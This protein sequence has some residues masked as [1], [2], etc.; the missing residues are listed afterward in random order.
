M[1]KIL[2]FEKQS[3]DEALKIVDSLRANGHKAFFV[4]GC[5]RD[6]LLG[7]KPGEIDITTSARPDEVQRLFLRTVPIGESFGVVLVLSNEQQ[8]E[9]ATFRTESKYNDGRHPELVKYSKSEKEDVLRRD[10]TI[11]GLLYDPFK[12]EL[13]DYTDG[14]ADLESNIIRTIGNPI[15]RFS[16]DKLRMIRAVRFASRFGFEIENE[17]Y[18]AI[19]SKAAD[20]NTISVER[21]REEIVKIITQKNPGIGLKMLKDSGLLEHILPEVSDMS[22]VKQPPEFHPEGDVF[23]HTCLVLDKL[24]ENT[25]G[26]YSDELAMGALLHDIGKPPTFQDLD[27]IRFNG[28]DRV[29]AKMAQKICKDL[30]FSKK[31]IERIS[32]IVRDHLKFKDAFSMRESTLK[33]FLGQPYFHEHLEMHLADCMASHGITKV[34][35]FLKDKLEEYSELDI[36]PE[37]LI[38][39]KD[40]ISMG[41]KPGPIFT[42]ILNATEEKQ[43]E[44]KITNKDEAIEFVNKTFSVN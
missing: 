42:T 13:F 1:K 5:V 34:Y 20:I 6:S 14:L 43:L 27:R 22:G 33:R 17:T 19:T 2:D 31:Q 26:E 39:G 15:E 9:V 29:G 37:P 41:Y 32:D 7:F 28:H 25:N 36:R 40:L 16:E 21:I 30:R 3:Y 35:Y 23:V 24:Y 11:N 4:G 8:F 10:F 44:G 18:S 12:N 38:N